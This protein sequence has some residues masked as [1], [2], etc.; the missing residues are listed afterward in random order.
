[1]KHQAKA[2][3]DDADDRPQAASMMEAISQAKRMVTEMTGLEVDA[4]VSCARGEDLNWRVALDII[5]SP[6][7]MGDNDLLTTYE[8][9]I[10]AG[11]E[12]LHF[13][14]LRRYHREDRD[15]G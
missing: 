1:M 13:A 2:Q 8:V 11:A 10:G 6:A 14:R 5:E 9:Q 3:F 4:V 7:R 15:S 12:P